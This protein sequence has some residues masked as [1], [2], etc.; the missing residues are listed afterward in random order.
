MGTSLLG[1]L[2]VAPR[3]RLEPQVE[4]DVGHERDAQ[5]RVVLSKEVSTEALRWDGASERFGPASP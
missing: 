2:Q 3:A 4:G 5:G 1:Q